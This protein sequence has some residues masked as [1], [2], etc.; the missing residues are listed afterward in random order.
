M[1]VDDRSA[2]LTRQEFD[3]LLEYSLSVPTGTTIGKRWKRKCTDCWLMGEYEPDP[4]KKEGWVQIRWRVIL[5][6]IEP[7]VRKE[8]V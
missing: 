1:L 2:I 5:E 8:A 7:P 3:E 4:E 6:I